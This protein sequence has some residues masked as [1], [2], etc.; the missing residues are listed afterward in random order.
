MNEMARRRLQAEGSVKEAAQLAVLRAFGLEKSAALSSQTY[1]YLAGKDP[2][3]AFNRLTTGLGAGAGAVVGGQLGGAIGAIRGAYNAEDG[4]ANRL[5]GGLVG[6]L[7]GS[8]VGTVAGGALG[9]AG[10]RF[11]PK[12]VRNTMFDMVSLG[13]T[14]AEVRTE[15][16]RRAA[17]DASLFR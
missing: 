1:K 5:K 10:G 12:N 14:P 3:Q 7:K 17:Q 6:G 4:F 9:A 11:A 2:T 13:H 16:L 8:V 15:L